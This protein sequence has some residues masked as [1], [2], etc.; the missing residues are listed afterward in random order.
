MDISESNFSLNHFH[1]FTLLALKIG[2]G[3]LCKRGIRNSIISIIT[4]RLQ[5]YYTF[6]VFFVS[7]MFVR[8]QVGKVN[9]FRSRLRLFLES[10][11]LLYFFIIYGSLWRGLYILRLQTVER[12]TLVA[13]L[14]VLIVWDVVYFVYLVYLM[15]L[16]YIR[17]LRL[18]F[19]NL[20]NWIY[21]LLADLEDC[22]VNWLHYWNYFVYLRTLIH[23]VYFLF[24]AQ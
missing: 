15:D 6:L 16:V 13:L 23:F 10:I 14:L 18:Q 3:W 4:I 20:L 12:V 8:G 11:F 24:V 19:L 17:Y 7:S 22:I 2:I 5:I 9:I 1:I 21:Y